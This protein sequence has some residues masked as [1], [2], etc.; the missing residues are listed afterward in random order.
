MPY[1]HQEHT[2][3]HLEVNSLEFLRNER[4][5]VT[6]N[7]NPRGDK[8]HGGDEDDLILY[9]SLNKHSI[10]ARAQRKKKLTPKAMVTIVPIASA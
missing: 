9:E 10:H 4:A 3:T 6:A 1:Q 5:S 7:H 2:R 8:E